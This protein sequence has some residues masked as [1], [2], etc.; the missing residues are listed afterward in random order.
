[1]TLIFELPS[2]LIGHKPSKGP[3]SEAIRS[4]LLHTAQFLNVTGS[5]AFDGAAWWL[6]TIQTG[7]FECIKWLSSVEAAGQL[8]VIE[9]ISADWMNKEQWRFCSVGFKD[10]DR[11][12]SLQDGL[13]AQDTRQPLNRCSL[14]D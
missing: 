7:R 2:H 1:M 4:C 13:V 10:H 9:N 11:R 3:A 5:Q 12:R 6:F 8:K 14:K